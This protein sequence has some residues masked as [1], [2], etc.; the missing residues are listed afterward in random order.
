MRLFYVDFII[1]MRNGKVFLFDT[2]TEGSD[3]DAVEKHNAL[4]DYIMAE[5]SRGANLAGGIII[6]DSMELWK[7]S[8]MK[9]DTTE[10][11]DGWSTFHP[12]D[13]K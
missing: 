2:K 11:L 12:S 3:P 1:R 6:Q 10:S 8:P 9:I 5:N 13:Y 7:Y 4:I